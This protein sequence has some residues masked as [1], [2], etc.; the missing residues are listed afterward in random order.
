MYGGS[1]H[2]PAIVLAELIAG[3]HDENSHITLPGFYDSVRPISEQERVEMARL[4]MNDEAVK[5]IT[6]VSMPY[7]EA[8]YTTAERIGA[9]PTLD[10]NGMVSGFT[11]VG[12]KT[13]LPA[14]A[15]AK[16]SMR[17]VRKRCTS[18]CASTSKNTRPRRYT[19][20]LMPWP[21]A[22]RRYRI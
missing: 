7:G 21:V 15:M 17:L 20:N 8:G 13:V 22:P 16:I 11:G 19:G 4:P 3:M 5:E 1:V 10:V 2:N 18:S 14:F 12:S 9:R 6:G